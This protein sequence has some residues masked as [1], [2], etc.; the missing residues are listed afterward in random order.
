MN[1]GPNNSQTA[2]W[3]SPTA[4]LPAGVTPFQITNRQLN[5][6][7]NSPKS[8]S[9]MVAAGWIE[10]VR[11]GKPGRESLFDFQSAVW[12]YE[13][14]KAGEEP[15]LLPSEQKRGGRP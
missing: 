1:V 10:T 9:R 6:L 8:V 2:A 5:S 3:R 13:R 12:A 7:F 4:A 14:L 15:P 11:K